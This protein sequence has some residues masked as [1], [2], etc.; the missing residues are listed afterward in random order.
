MAR[1]GCRGGLR[2]LPWWRPVVTPGDRPLNDD[3]R[4]AAAAQGAQLDPLARALLE[5][6]N[7]L[8][9]EEQRALEAWTRAQEELQASLEAAGDTS[10]RDLLDA[11]ENQARA[12]EA[13][14]Q[15][16]STDSASEAS[17]KVRQ[18][19]RSPSRSPGR[20]NATWPAKPWK[21]W[22]TACARPA[23]RS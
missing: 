12:A 23:A 1:S 6:R 19:K 17:R 14:A 20:A 13:L 3:Q 2:L 10:P 7:A 4:A 9:S 21:K 18:P 16:L 15:Q 22:P 11:L 5:Q 8:T